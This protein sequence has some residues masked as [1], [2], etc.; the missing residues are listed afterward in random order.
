MSQ[1][2]DPFAAG[3]ESN[4]PSRL[5]SISELQDEE[6]DEAAAAEKA[7]DVENRSVGTET[8]EMMP[9][10]RSK[11]MLLDVSSSVGSGVPPDLSPRYFMTSMS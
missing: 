6:E 10:D 11:H 5:T 7:K 1:Q 3:F 8:I 9:L 2:P 4:R